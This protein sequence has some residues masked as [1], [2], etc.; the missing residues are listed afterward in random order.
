MEGKAVLSKLQ[1]G[2][3]V[4]VSWGRSFP[5]RGHTPGEG[6]GRTEQAEV[7]LQEYPEW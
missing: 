7:G 5:G 4:G 6:L 2:G 1:P 3:Q